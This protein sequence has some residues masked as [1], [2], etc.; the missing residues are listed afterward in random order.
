[1]RRWLPRLAPVAPLPPSILA[2]S[3]AP[4]KAGD[5]H[6]S[7]RAIPNRYIA[8]PRSDA[9]GPRVKAAAHS[10]A[11]QHVG[12][13]RHVCEHAM[14]GSS[15]ETNADGSHQTRLTFNKADYSLNAWQ[16]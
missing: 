13:V 5:I 6:R 4:V 7:A 14:R 10:L 12:A 15:A 16:P 2:L 1:M 3:A 9:V 11:A 8:A